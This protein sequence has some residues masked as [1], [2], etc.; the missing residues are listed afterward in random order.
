MVNEISTYSTYPN[1]SSNTEVPHASAEGFIRECLYLLQSGVSPNRALGDKCSL[2][3]TVFQY[4]GER[5]FDGYLGLLLPLIEELIK[6]SANFQE[7]VIE[8]D[9]GI[10]CIDFTCQQVAFIYWKQLAKENH[11]GSSIAQRIFRLVD[12]NVSYNA[13]Y[14]DDCLAVGNL[15]KVTSFL[16]STRLNP[17]RMELFGQSIMQRV[18]QDLAAGFYEDILQDVPDLIQVLLENRG[19]P[20]LQFPSISIKGKGK[21]Q[22]LT[23]LHI[24]YLY[25]QGLKKKGQSNAAKL[26]KQA[27]LLLLQDP[28]IDV[29]LRF[30]EISLYDRDSGHFSDDLYE[31][32]YLEKGN[33][34]H[35]ALA[36]GDF[37]TAKKVLSLA[38]NLIGSTCFTVTRKWMLDTLKNCYMASFIDPRSQQ[39]IQLFDAQLYQPAVNA[40]KNSS[41]T[42][43]LAHLYWSY[44]PGEKGFKPKISTVI[45]YGRVSLCHIAARRLDLVA[46]TVLTSIGDNGG[47]P[48]TDRRSVIDYA[49][50]HQEDDLIWNKREKIAKV[51]F[52]A[53]KQAQPLPPVI[54]QAFYT[55]YQDGYEAMYHPGTK[56]SIVREVL[57]EGMLKAKVSNSEH[58]SYRQHPSIPKINRAS[59]QDFKVE[60]VI[61][62]HAKPRADSLS[63]GQSLYDVG[64]LTNIL[65][66]NSVLNN[67]LWKKIEKQIRDLTQIHLCLHV[68]TGGVFT[69]SVDVK[70]PKIVSYPVIG[71]GE[72]SMPTHFFK[73]V[74]AFDYGTGWRGFAYLIPN[75]PLPYNADL[76]QY[77][78][79]IERI[80]ELSGCNF[81][82][83]YG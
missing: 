1:A 38:R 57:H 74:Y 24:A 55:L 29:T 75:I 82:G 62:G 43:I 60:G 64:Y 7:R 68:Y 53:L 83:F 16:R 10:T 56:C 71:Q 15:Q 3:E 76:Q 25:W 39:E 18:F 30:T 63:S 23:C 27:F 31:G 37:R 46:C 61:C 79:C 49:K 36:D 6:K 13:E 9:H 32:D 35:Y 26:I 41:L 21:Y 54:P 22:N 11:V 42:G 45:R 8:I 67:G 19:D 20:N 17:N 65:A 44:P 69:S 47:I 4:L 73:V 58:K 33:L 51:V 34:A 70:G 81:K 2:V 12:Q 66:Q 40:L 72:V 77:F 50:L 52:K 80:Q 48:D 5:R 78:V 14:I 28:R 59:L